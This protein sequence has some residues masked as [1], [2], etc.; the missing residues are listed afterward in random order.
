MGG[1][2]ELRVH[3]VKEIGKMIEYLFFIELYKLF[4]SF[5]INEYISLE[6]TNRNEKI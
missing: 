5:C 2:A 6:I 3:K 4:K 1:S